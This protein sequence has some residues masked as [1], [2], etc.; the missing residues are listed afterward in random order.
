MVHLL[1]SYRRFGLI[2][3][4]LRQ[5]RIQT[6]TLP[7]LWRI[8]LNEPAHSIRCPRPLT[9]AGVFFSSVFSSFVTAD[10]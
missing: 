8:H 4:V 6:D 7:E 1:S 3:P 10:V 5:V 2:G 9:K